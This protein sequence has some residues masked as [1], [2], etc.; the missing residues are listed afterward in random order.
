MP[1]ES[2]RGARERFTVEKPLQIEIIAYAPTAYYHCQHC[3]VVWQETGFSKG[4]R[5]EQL[6][7]G[8]PEDMLN[9]YAAVSDWVRRLLREYCDRVMVQVIDAASIEGVWKSLKYG[10]RRYPAVVIDGQAKSIGTDFAMADASIAR[11]LA[12]V[13]S[14]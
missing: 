1:C 6:G 14:A 5:Q 12:A 11:R 10:V 8:L 4:V 7:S 2:G 9:E 3:E 13:P